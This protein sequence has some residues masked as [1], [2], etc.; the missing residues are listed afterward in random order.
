MNIL[1]LDREFSVQELY[2]ITRRARN[3]LV[4]INLFLH[5]QQVMMKMI[6]NN[7]KLFFQI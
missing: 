5:R 7:L 2:R 3:L 6:L 1:M 4:Q